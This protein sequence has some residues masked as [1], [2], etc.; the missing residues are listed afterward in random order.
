MTWR[1]PKGRTQLGVIASAL[2]APPSEAYSNAI[3][4]LIS[5]LVEK[6][7]SLLYYYSDCNKYVSLFF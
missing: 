3:E 5:R 1:S 7:S 4:F 2:I 6:Y